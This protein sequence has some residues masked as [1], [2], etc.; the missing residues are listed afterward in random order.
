MGAFVVLSVLVH[1]HFIVPAHQ[2]VVVFFGTWNLEQE[3]FITPPVYFEREYFR[4]IH[5]F[6][7]V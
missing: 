1:L 3:A 6:V 2:N 7:N 4:Y 5:A